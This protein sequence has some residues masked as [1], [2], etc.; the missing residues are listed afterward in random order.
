MRW[1]WAAAIGLVVLYHAAAFSPPALRSPHTV[2]RRGVRRPAATTQTTDEIELMKEKV[3]RVL[4]GD[5]AVLPP[6]EETA[7]T[8]LEMQDEQAL[9]SATQAEAEAKSAA[10]EKALAE[11]KADAEDPR[12]H[13]FP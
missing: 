3:R 10:E 9:E 12:G 2:I 7:R 5:Q 6:P 13:P 1:L 11:E 4:L 8:M